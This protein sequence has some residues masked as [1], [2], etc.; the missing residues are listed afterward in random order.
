MTRSRDHETPAETGSGR[1]DLS[2]SR[3][4]PI[5]LTEARERLTLSIAEAAYLMG[6]S[7]SWLYAEAER[8]GLPTRRCK[9]RVLVLAQPFLAGFTDRQA[10]S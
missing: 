9:G 3:S 10:A 2:R 1:P 7:S 8:G 4:K 6:V 5:T